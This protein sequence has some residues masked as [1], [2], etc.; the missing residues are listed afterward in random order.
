LKS[1]AV[2]VVIYPINYDFCR[3]RKKQ[4][5]MNDFNPNK[6]SGL[7]AILPLVVFLVT[8]LLVSLLAGDF[9]KMPI[10]IAFLVSGI[11][12]ILT[13][14]GLK[15]HRRIDVFIRGAANENIMLMVLIFILAGA[16]SG[17]AK[18]MGAV[19]ASVNLIL[20]VIPESLLL[21]GVFLAACLISLAMGTSVGTIV[22]L[23]PV[24]I[25]LAS[26]TDLSQAMMVGVVIGG[27]MFGD[28][29]S[30]IS[31]TTIVAVRTQGCAMKDKFFANI[32]IVLPVVIIVFLVYIFLGFNLDLSEAADR[33]I[34]WL[35]VI[36]YLFVLIGAG[37]GMNVLL[38][39]LSG[40]VLTG[41]SGFVTGTLDIWQWL[42]A[43]NKGIL[44]MGELIVVTLLAGGV[45]ETIRFNGGISWIIDKMTRKVSNKRGAE[46]SIFGLVMLAN[47][48]TANNT[49][50]L[51]M[52]GPIAKDIAHRFDIDPRRSASL[53]D[54]VSCFV[55]G[56]IPYGAQVL[57]AC[58][59]S[60]LS[61]L[62]IIPWLFYPFLMG[63]AVLLAILFR[64]PRSFA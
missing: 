41:I 47:V 49:I 22:A 16:F 21:A 39:L 20:D 42:D 23:T 61:P 3:I 37:A 1:L 46:F 2:N 19:D 58:G 60:G 51:I 40:I 28:N 36:P 9:Y 13:T 10:V 38:V 29:L 7:V 25:G 30:F 57:I 11:T 48:C 59:L 56:M 24:A 52:S 62:E 14:G 17:S 5:L 12:G 45:L 8:Y 32:K 55:Q 6:R 35:K 53:L 54:T 18:A 27:A 50:A 63:V 43:L 44:G 64:Y 33:N 26:R 34:E 15:L 4:L 31:D